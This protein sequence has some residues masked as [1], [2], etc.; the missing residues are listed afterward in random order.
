MALQHQLPGRRVAAD[1]LDDDLDLRVVHH[2]EG[3]VADA[4]D[5]LE[6]G[7]AVGLVL[8]RRGVGDLDAAPGAPRDLPGVAGEHRHRAAAD[9]TQAQQSDLDRFH[10]SLL[11]RQAIH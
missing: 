2:R 9:G 5:L 6:P 3:V 8:A 7:D 4:P 11:D 1:Q 10:T